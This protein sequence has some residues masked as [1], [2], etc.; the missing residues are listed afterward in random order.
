VLFREGPLDRVKLAVLGE[1]LDREDLRA[2][3]L[4]GEDRAGLCRTA[5][6]ENGTGAALARVATDMRAGEVESLAQELD[7]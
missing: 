7:K 4:D 1:T 5:V 2:I 3:G 6:D